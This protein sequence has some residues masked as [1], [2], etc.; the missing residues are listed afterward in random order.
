VPLLADVL[1]RST[2]N[3]AIFTPLT[4]FPSSMSL[5][6][7][8]NFAIDAQVLSLP[9]NFGSIILLQSSTAREAKTELANVLLKRSVY[10]SELAPY[11]DLAYSRFQFNSNLKQILLNFIGKK[12]DAPILDL[13]GG[14]GIFTEELLNLGYRNV[15]IADASNHM[16]DAAR[17]KLAKYNGF[18]PSSSY[19]HVRM[20]DISQQFSE[21][22]FQAIVIRQ[23]VNYIPP[24]DLVSTF[25]GIRKAILPDG[26]FFF[27]SFIYSTSYS[28]ITR[29]IRHQNNSNIL[30]TKENTMILTAQGEDYTG[31]YHYHGQQTDIFDLADGQ[32]AVIYD[33]NKF[34]I[35]TPEQFVAALKQ[36]GFADVK[37][38]QIKSSC[39]LEAS[40]M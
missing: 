10:Q 33:L 17:N 15:H 40:V 23:A 21:P 30:T 18:M 1:K 14:T 9:C 39:Y 29:C 32:H 28:P 12:M 13:C 16:L 35:H 5:D 6:A 11:Y 4:R 38:S 31:S 37:L 19:V 24:G 3:I 27:N 8:K 7:N 26:R 20:E 25:E 22:K 34:Y 36:A 2:A